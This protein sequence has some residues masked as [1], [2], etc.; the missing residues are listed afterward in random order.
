MPLERALDH[1]PSVRVTCRR[2]RTGVGR[3]RA[4]GA[5]PDRSYRR[6]RDRVFLA[7]LELDVLPDATLFGELEHESGGSCVFHRDSN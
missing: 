6:R 1:S 2:Q 3:K 7:V 5:C 4:R